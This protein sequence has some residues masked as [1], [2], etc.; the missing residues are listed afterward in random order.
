MAVSGSNRH[1]RLQDGCKGRGSAAAVPQD[2]SGSR[3]ARSDRTTKLDLDS[4]RKSRSSSPQLR[5]LYFN[6][7]SILSKQ[8]ELSQLVACDAASSPHLVAISETWLNGD[9]PDGSVVLPGYS[10]LFRAD[11]VGGLCGGGR[12]VLRSR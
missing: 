2:L 7:R 6:A 3:L 4:P 8:V 5:L 12:A 9:V 11:R 10:S 1:S